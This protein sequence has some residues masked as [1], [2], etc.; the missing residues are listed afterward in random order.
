MLPISPEAS[1]CT[2]VQSAIDDDARPD[3]GADGD[4][5]HI[6]DV[7]PGS[8]PQLAQGRQVDI[9]IDRDGQ[10]DSARSAWL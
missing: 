7:L 1:L 10:V 9:V 2:T 5:D 6:L 3:A 8:K 4:Q